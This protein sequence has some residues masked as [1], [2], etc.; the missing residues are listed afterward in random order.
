[1]RKCCCLIWPE[2]E[3]Y[4]RQCGRRHGTSRILRS[5]IPLPPRWRRDG[6]DVSCPYGMRR[7]V[8]AAAAWSCCW[9]RVISAWRQVGHRQPAGCAGMGTTCGRSAHQ[10]P[11]SPL[12]QVMELPQREQLVSM[13]E[14]RSL[15][16]F[17][18]QSRRF[19]EAVGCERNA[20]PRLAI[21]RLSCLEQTC[22]LGSGRMKVHH[23]GRH[24]GKLW[25]L[26]SGR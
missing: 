6:H 16:Q 23:H 19:S 11:P 17:A 25:C 20:K 3:A 22:G 9:R 14:Y 12:P 2:A 8:T 18:P 21:G 15:I 1:M 5:V 4:G 26:G 7:N 13:R 24:Q 10:Q